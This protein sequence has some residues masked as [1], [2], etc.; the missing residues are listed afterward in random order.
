MYSSQ[1]PT[2][3]PT[4]STNTCYRQR[5][6]QVQH[7]GNCGVYTEEEEEQEE[8]MHLKVQLCFTVTFNSAPYCLVQSC[9]ERFVAL[10]LCCADTF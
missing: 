3:S 2:N 7:N 8:E 1:N 6:K 4:C 9:V 5:L 10:N